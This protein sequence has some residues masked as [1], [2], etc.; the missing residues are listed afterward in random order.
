MNNIYF[1]NCKGTNA[2][3]AYCSPLLYYNFN[4]NIEHL[5]FIKEKNKI[6]NI[7]ESILIFGGGGILDTNTIHNSFY[8]KID[9]S[10]ICIHWG[11]G[12]NGLNINN[13][14]WKI[15]NNEINY[16]KDILENFKIIG[17]RDYINNYLPNHEYVPCVSCKLEG[18]IKKYEIKRRVG[19]LEHMFLHKIKLKYSKI[20]MNLKKYNIDQIIKFI[21]ESDVIFTSSYHG[22]YW[23]TLMNKKVIIKT[24]WSDKF[25]YF[26]YKPVIYSGDIEKDIEKAKTYPKSLEECIKLNDN[27]YKKINN[28]LK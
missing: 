5:S 22:M 11:S 26:K 20:T 24:N 8:K 23:A 28:I 14:N 10:N 12:S 19:I 3:D 9:K 1:I 27:F 7:K 25:D 21:G 18:L 17:R 16:K 2:G 15:N 6:L 4:T 13:I